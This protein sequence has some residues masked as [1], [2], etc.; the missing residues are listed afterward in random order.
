MR[1]QLFE[2]DDIP[3]IA[4]LGMGSRR[5]AP[6]RTVLEGTFA[7]YAESKSPSEGLFR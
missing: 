1:P 7:K 6:E 5:L 4:A 2:A 3:I